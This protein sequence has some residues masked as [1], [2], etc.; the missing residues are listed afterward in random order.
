[1]D[2]AT[3]TPSVRV[4]YAR[5]FNGESEQTMFFSNLGAGSQNYSIRTEGMPNQYGS[6]GIGMRYK[7][8]KSVAFDVAY[9]A[10]YGSNAYRAN[11]VRLDANWAF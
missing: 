1:M 2:S 8:Q 5:N 10:S 11:T 4:Q 6:I 7:R 3:L 9:T